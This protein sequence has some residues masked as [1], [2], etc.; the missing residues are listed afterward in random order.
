[1]FHDVTWTQEQAL[2]LIELFLN[3]Q[4]RIQIET[5]Y[6]SPVGFNLKH[7]GK[8]YELSLKRL[9]D[10]SFQIRVIDPGDIWVTGYYNSPLWFAKYRD[11]VIKS[12][13]E[14]YNNAKNHVDRKTKE[15]A[16]KKAEELQGIASK[17]AENAIRDL[18]DKRFENEVLDG[19]EDSE[20]S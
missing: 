9:K 6:N 15:E 1:M 2:A 20:K 8:A 13:Y 4:Q 18:I 11:P 10:N 3:N 14:L 5:S 19:K 7:G 16:R 12:A 17:A